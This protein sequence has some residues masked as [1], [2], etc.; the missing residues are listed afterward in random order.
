M[1]IK[2]AYDITTAESCENG[3]FSETGWEDEEGFE[4]DSVDNAVRWMRKHAPLEASCYPWGADAWYTETSDRIG[5]GERRLSFHLVDFTY[6]Q[7]EDLY[8]QLK[9]G[10]YVH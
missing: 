10:H 9:G 3:D 1:L 7:A 4:F 8:K 2:I 6:E 5:F